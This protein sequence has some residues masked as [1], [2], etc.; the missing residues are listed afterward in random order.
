MTQAPSPRGAAARL[1]DPRVAV[2]AG[3]LAHA[4]LSAY[5]N[6]LAQN[7]LE[8]SDARLVLESALAG[9]GAGAAG[10]AARRLIVPAARR[11]FQQMS[12]PRQAQIRAVLAA[13]PEINNL[14]AYLPGLA[15]VAGAGVGAGLAGGVLAPFIAGNLNLLGLPGWSGRQQDFYEQDQSSAPLAAADLQAIQGLMP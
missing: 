6:A 3:I 7:E 9:L 1:L 10:V 12:A 11:G 14:R 8:K 2:P 5:G 15:G 13:N 4:G